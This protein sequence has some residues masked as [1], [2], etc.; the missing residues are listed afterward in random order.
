MVS[1]SRRTVT[2]AIIASCGSFACASDPRRPPGAGAGTGARGGAPA[3]S[4]ASVPTDAGR[5]ARSND[6]ADDDDGGPMPPAPDAGTDAGHDAGPP[7]PPPPPSTSFEPAARGFSA[8]FTLKLTAA[9]PGDAVHYTLD[10][11]VPTVNSPRYSEPLAI[12]GSTLVRAIAAR[13]G[14][15][16]QVADQAYVQLADD[17]KGF[18][19]NLP[20]LVVH[21]L[22]EAAPETWDREYVPAVFLQFEPG[23][24]GRTKLDGPAT[25]SARLGIKVRGRSTREQPKHSYSIELWGDNLEDAPHALLGMPSDGDWVLYA[26]Y[27]Y[28]R[29]LV[30]NAFIYEI[31]QRIG[32]YAARSRFCELYLVTDT[33]ALAKAS[34]MGI[35]ALTERLTRGA[36]RIPIQKLSPSQ[37]AEPLVSGGYIF[38]RDM[39]DLPEEAFDAGGQTFLYAEPHVDEIVPKQSEYLIDYLDAWQRAIA[40]EDGLDPETGKAYTALMDSASFIDHHILNMLAKN[41]DAFALSAY[42]HKDRNGPLQA[43]PIWDFDIAMAGNDAWGDRTLDPTHWGPGSEDTIFSRAHYDALFAHPEFEAAYWKRLDE[44]LAST[45]KSQDFHVLLDGWKAQLTEAEARNRARWPE[46]AP[47]NGSFEEEIQVLETWLDR[48]LEWIAANKGDVP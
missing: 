29:A 43:G 37:V 13:A 33:G 6:A 32:R 11:S 40:A 8:P 21:R 38:Q 25:H 42:F 12:A 10:G 18:D 44:L 5:D 19:S 46:A 45:F 3:L 35:Y 26:P 1:I 17:A 24:N 4:D 41:P 31:S 2:L 9:V 30:R 48:R 7:P 14:L 36:Q 20:V 34:Y 15:A 47:R 16:G 39:A 23:A 22:G 28:D 27:I